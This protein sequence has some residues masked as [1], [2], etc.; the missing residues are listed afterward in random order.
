MEYTF[1]LLNQINHSEADN[2][3]QPLIWQPLSI[4]EFLAFNQATTTLTL[5]QSEARIAE[6]ALLLADKHCQT[7]VV[8]AGHTH[9]QPLVSLH[10]AGNN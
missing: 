4:F 8:T 9:T 7:K 6:Q 10:L 5:S 2:H 3:Y 1:N